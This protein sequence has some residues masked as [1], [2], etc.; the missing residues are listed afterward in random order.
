MVC[1]VCRPND[2]CGVTVDWYRFDVKEYRSATRELADAEDLA[3]RRLIDLYYIGEGPLPLDKDT[4]VKAVGLDWDCIQPVIDGYFEATPQGY[5]N[6][7]LQENLDRRIR[8]RMMNVEAGRLGG[9]K[10]KVDK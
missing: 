2:L 6:Q 9:R 5:L 8:K 3:F 4:L 10:K 1:S 7:A